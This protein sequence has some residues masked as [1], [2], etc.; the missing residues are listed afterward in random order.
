MLRAVTL[1]EGGKSNLW[2]CQWSHS[3]SGWV[4]ETADLKASH[5]NIHFWLHLV[6]H[7]RRTLT[8]SP[9][10]LHL[11][12]LFQDSQLCQNTESPLEV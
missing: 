3:N 9:G 12:C 10:A 4:F 1:S 7:T 2:L 8:R 5:A 6:K 11:G